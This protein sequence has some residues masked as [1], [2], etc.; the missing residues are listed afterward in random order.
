MDLYVYDRE[1]NLLGVLDGYTS[2]RWLRSYSKTGEFELHCAYTNRNFELLQPENII[3]KSDSIEGGLIDYLEINVN[4][5]NKEVMTV[6]GSLLEGILNRRIIW[7]TKNYD[8]TVEL[9]IRDLITTQVIAPT[10]GNRKIGTIQLGSLKSLPETIKY[11][12]SYQN[13]L[14]QIEILCE[15]NQ[16]GHRLLIDLPSKKLKFDIYKGADHSAGQSVNP[17][18]IFNK[19]FDN[20]L[21]H[22]YIHSRMDYRNVCLVGGMGEGTARRLI[23]VGSGSGYDRLEAFADQKSVTNVVDNVTLT[24]A[25]YNALLSGKG[26][27]LLMESR[28][29]EKFDIQVNLQSNL[30]YHVDYELGDIVTC[31][32]NKWGINMNARITEIE[33]VYEEKG[34]EL[35]IVF[36]NDL[37]TLKDKLKGVM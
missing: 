22:E 17:R 36:G 32:S 35:S 25:Q 19:E 10:D 3:R 31:Q 24:D 16:L 20:V 2:L 14:N 34:P 11:Q 27:E 23:T 18:C 37:L 4:I 21:D 1:L 26:Q 5:E 13:L 7:G 9:A 28:V 29:S 15:T 30:Q 12:V 6:T 33:E 8:T